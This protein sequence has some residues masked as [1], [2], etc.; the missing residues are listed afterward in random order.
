MQ[1]ILF[2]VCGA[3]LGRPVYE[4]GSD[5][6]LLE[7]LPQ[8]SEYVSAT[9]GSSWWSGETHASHRGASEHYAKCLAR[10]GLDPEGIDCDYE[11]LALNCLNETSEQETHASCD[12]P[13]GTLWACFTRTHQEAKCTHWNPTVLS[14]MTTCVT[15]VERFLSCL[16]S[17]MLQQKNLKQFLTS[18]SLT[19]C[20]A[21]FYV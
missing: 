13:A 6:R 9:R 17:P 14:H 4:F 11:A 18:Y 5:A 21:V 8:M 3:S 15:S 10:L 12:T 2:L 7:T 19:M 16:T 20:Q 1:V